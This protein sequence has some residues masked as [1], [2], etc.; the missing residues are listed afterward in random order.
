MINGFG[1]MP[2][3]EKMCEK[4]DIK[5]KMCEKRDIKEKMY[6]KCNIPILF[7]LQWCW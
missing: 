6:E 1:Y 3:K 5:E 2:R 4:R 7:K